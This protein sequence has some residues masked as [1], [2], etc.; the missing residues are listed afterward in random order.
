[1]LV[2][3]DNLPCATMTEEIIKNNPNLPDLKEKVIPASM[4]K[5]GIVA[6]VELPGKIKKGDTV[7]VVYTQQINNS[8]GEI[9][10]LLTAVS[11][12]FTSIFFNNA[13]RAIGSVRVNRLRL[14]V[15]T[16]ILIA[17]HWLFIGAPF[18]IHATEEQWFWL[19]LSGIIGL[20]LGDAFLFQAYVHIGPRL[21]TVIMALDPVISAVIAWLWLGEKLTLVEVV[22]ILIT[23]FGVGWVV[24]E[25]S[26]GN[27]THSRKDLI[28]GSLCGIGAVLGQAIGFVLSKKGLANNFS[29]LSG[30]LIRIH[31]RCR[32]NVD[33]GNADRK[34]QRYLGTV[35]MTN[36]PEIILSQARLLDPQ[37]GS[38][39]RW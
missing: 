24:L 34:I 16:V 10:A 33:F 8:M 9:A 21:T 19:G 35:S 30:V 6:V 29:P 1:M 37:W 18:P 25:R 36:Q 20:A 12:S 39:Y 3:A 4:G 26:N 2:T 15:A 14:L 27:G 5:R 32:R 7:R 13:S 22:G 17:A 38:G 23:V 31:D 11:W 28:L